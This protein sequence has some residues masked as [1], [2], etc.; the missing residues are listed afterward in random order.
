MFFF[1][2]LINGFSETSIAANHYISIY[3]VNID[4]HS[5]QTDCIITTSEF[6]SSGLLN[7]SVMLHKKKETSNNLEKTKS[8]F[9]K[10]EN[11]FIKKCAKS[12]ASINKIPNFSPNHSFSN[13]SNLK[14]SLNK[15]LAIQKVFSFSDKLKL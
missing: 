14:I 5:K 10:V 8:L 7:E 4:N 9:E 6:N 2:F 15:L 12:L 1:I 13:D 11:A 3:N